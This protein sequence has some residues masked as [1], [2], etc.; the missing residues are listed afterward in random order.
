M[1]RNDGI[2]KRIEEQMQTGA[3]DME[4]NHLDEI[5]GLKKIPQ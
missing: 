3:E 2:L 1:F 4:G 5:M